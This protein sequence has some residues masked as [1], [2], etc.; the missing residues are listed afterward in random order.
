MS[1]SSTGD[2]AVKKK[3]VR[4]ARMEEDDD[5]VDQDEDTLFDKRKDARRGV[6]SVI[7][8]SRK[9]A[10]SGSDRVAVR[11]GGSSGSGGCVRWLVTLALC[12]SFLGLVMSI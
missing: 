7:K 6:K 10:N 8:G 3:Q 2:P 11:G 12:G 1:A 5:N 4:F 9:L